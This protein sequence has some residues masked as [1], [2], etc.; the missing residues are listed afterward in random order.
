MQKEKH[1]VEVHIFWGKQWTGSFYQETEGQGI[2][3]TVEEHNENGRLGGFSFSGCPLGRV[4]DKTF[5]DENAAIEYAIRD[6]IMYGTPEYKGPSQLCREMIVI[7]KV[8]D[9]RKPGAVG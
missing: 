5:P 7:H 3:V 9:F 1:Y 8:R 4:Y 2:A 6:Y